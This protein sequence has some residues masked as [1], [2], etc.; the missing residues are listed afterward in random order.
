MNRKLAPPG[1]YFYS[2]M[3]YNNGHNRYYAL[4]MKQ[5]PNKFTR[6]YT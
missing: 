3:S 6:E 5:T 1:K 4:K 2:V